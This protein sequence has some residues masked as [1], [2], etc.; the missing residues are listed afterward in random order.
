[1]GYRVAAVGAT[2]ALPSG[3]G[4]QP[5]CVRSVPD[6]LR[7]GRAGGVLVTGS[8]GSSTSSAR[9]V[10]ARGGDGFGPSLDRA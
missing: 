10:V 6:R 5:C 3:L 8:P 7:A 2:G 9:G 1:M 4:L